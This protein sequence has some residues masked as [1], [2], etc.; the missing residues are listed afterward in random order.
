MSSERTAIEVRLRRHLEVLTVEIGPR[1]PATGDSLERAASYLQAELEGAGLRVERRAYAFQFRE[2]ANLVAWP[3]RAPIGEPFILV[4]AH[5]DTVPTTPGADDNGSGVAVLLEL[6][7][8]FA[9]TALPLRFVAFTMEEPPAHL[10]RE[11]GS[12]VFV[13]ELQRR[14][15][16]VRAAVI[17]EMVGYTAE[18]QHYPLVLRWAGYP[19]RGDFIGIIG[20]GRS[21]HLVRR[22]LASLRASGRPPVQA[23]VV[24]LRGWLLPAVRLSDHA[25]FWDVGIPAAMITDTAFF[26][27]PH[28]HLPSDRLETLDFEFMVDLVLALERGLADLLA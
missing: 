15:E 8:H 16:R 10:T 26:R 9:S 25:A 12:R 18:R 7:R 23:L 19:P 1:S 24:P 20:D 21:R 6:A 14:R 2:V 27:N 11:Q 22:L 4:G 13:R 5:Y 28:Y 3:P 17:L